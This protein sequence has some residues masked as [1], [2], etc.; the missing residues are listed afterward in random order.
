MLLLVI[1][2]LFLSAS[3]SQPQTKREEF[4]QLLGR[5]RGIAVDP[6]PE[7][8]PLDAQKISKNGIYAGFLALSE[9]A[10]GGAVRWALLDTEVSA[11]F[12]AD[13]RERVA[14]EVLSSKESVLGLHISDLRLPGKIVESSSAVSSVSFDLSYRDLPVRDAFVQV[15]FSKDANGKW[16]FREIVNNSF[17]HITVGNLGD[18][19]PRWDDIAPTVQED[20]LTLLNSRLVI[21]VKDTQVRNMSKILESG[22]E[23]RF[24][25]A[26]EFTAVDTGGTRQVITVEHGSHALLEAFRDRYSAGLSV[27]KAKVYKNSYLTNEYTERLLP[28]TSVSLEDRSEET[29]DD[30]GAVDLGSA[31]SIG[32]N[33]SSP[34]IKVGNASTRAVASFTLPIS[35]SAD[36][37]S[38]TVSP[39]GEALTA[40]NLYAS[41]IDV[42][43]M[44]RKHVKPSQTQ[45]LD[46]PPTALYNVAGECNAFYDPG[47]NSINLHRAGAT[48]VN[49]ALITD[50]GVHEWGHGLDYFTG[51]QGGIADGSFSEGIGDIL[52]SYM[53]NNPQIGVGIRSGSSKALRTV[54]NKRRYPDDVVFNRNQAGRSVEAVHETG[55]IIGGVFWDLRKALI[56]RYGGL[57][58]AWKAERLFLRHLLDTDSYR[59]SYMSVLRLDDDDSNTRSQSPNHCLINDAFAAHGLATDEGCNDPDLDMTWSKDIGLSLKAAEGDSVTIRASVVGTAAPKMGVCVVTASAYALTDPTDTDSPNYRDCID[60]GQWTEVMKKSGELNG[61]A[62]FEGKSPIEINGRTRVILVSLSDKEKPTKMREF[63]FEK[64]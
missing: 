1:L 52:A 10:D 43:R 19:A 60:S 44:V 20:R 50:V 35:R 5:G 61:R 59:Q 63:R 4:T 14:L 29:T 46:Q 47:A 41:L 3:C 27:L 17:G 8:V 48:C 45:I 51:R 11:A 54:D 62:M 33:L 37:S 30:V 16:R 22:P 28:K 7:L 34:Y 25:L 58:G 40:L 9:P 24:T 12:E 6:P 26:T 23:T 57:R 31:T 55:Q 15:V 36:K 38:A 13:T 49:I 64:K 42:N 32:I 21:F 56:E 39:S 2:G 53:L 18:V